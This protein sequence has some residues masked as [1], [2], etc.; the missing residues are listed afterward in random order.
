[1]AQI[2]EG[3]LTST[4]FAS[5]ATHLALSGN[6]VGAKEAATNLAALLSKVECLKTLELANSN[7]DIIELSR[8]LT[9][10]AI[11]S[12]EHLD[13]SFNKLSAL[14]VSALANGVSLCHRL[15]WLGL[16]S[17]RISGP[18]VESIIGSL[19][20]NTRLTHQ[21]LMVDI[22]SNE[23]GSHKVD[24]ECLC[25]VVCNSP[26]LYGLNLQDNKFKTRDLVG[27]INS[28]PRGSVRRIELGC[29]KKSQTKD[30]LGAI[31]DKCLVENGGCLESLIL[32][33]DD[34]RSYSAEALLPLLDAIGEN[35]SLLHLDISNNRIGEMV[36]RVVAN[37]DR[38][39][40]RQVRSEINLV[41]Y[42]I[43][44]H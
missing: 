29:V 11:R 12:L 19:S 15:C 18:D 20:Q 36:C 10:K 23:L 9:Y 27:L 16:R 39:R 25:R 4:S 41:A 30:V 8:V 42:G 33:G 32:N 34:K 31:I 22:G 13:L 14:H 44:C 17:C 5:S 6:D 28:L 7:V 38:A 35:R 2:L 3:L 26:N 40:V 1:M 21:L 43:L 37:G 24:A